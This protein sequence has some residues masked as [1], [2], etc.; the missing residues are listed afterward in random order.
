MWDSWHVP[1][2]IGTWHDT[3]WMANP[4]D[5]TV[6]PL[7]LTPS[8]VGLHPRVTVKAPWPG[9]A[10]KMDTNTFVASSDGQVIRSYV[11]RQRFAIYAAALKDGWL[12][13][14]I[15]K[16]F[17]PVWPAWGRVWAPS[18]EIAARELSTGT[19]RRFTLGEVARVDIYAVA[20]GIAWVVAWRV[21]GGLAIHRVDLAGAM[22]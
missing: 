11:G 14:S 15:P 19:E 5:G 12:W 3:L 2:P 9:T 13:M 21:S 6:G 20:P 1:A 8:S 4:L 17:L 18:L 7:L 16:W 10:A 22:Q